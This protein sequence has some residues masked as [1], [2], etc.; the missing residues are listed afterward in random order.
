MHY[1]KFA[2][3]WLDAQVAELREGL[4]DE[5]TPA[6]ARSLAEGELAYHALLL[7]DD[8][9][10]YL[11]VDGAIGWNSGVLGQVNRCARCVYARSARC[12]CVRARP[13]RPR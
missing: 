4:G 13:R 11:P 3:A 9:N 5:L 6:L 12:V 7:D 2:K 1:V 10:Y 8:L